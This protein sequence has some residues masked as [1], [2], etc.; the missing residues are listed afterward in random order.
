MA[1]I[2]L[3]HD[4]VQLGWLQFR[5]QLFAKNFSLMVP[6]ITQL[7][8]TR[9]SRCL[10]LWYRGITSTPILHRETHLITLPAPLPKR[11]ILVK[12]QFLFFLFSRKLRKSSNLEKSKF[13]EKYILGCLHY[14]LKGQPW[15]SPAPTLS[16]M[17]FMQSQGCQFFFFPSWQVKPR[18]S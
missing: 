14:N 5:F 8:S 7:V 12:L 6:T 3:L 13:T 2:N 18:I 9:I 11:F 10:Q 15:F 16:M 1:L 17:I 4:C